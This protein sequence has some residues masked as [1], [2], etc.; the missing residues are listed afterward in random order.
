MKPFI[1]DEN[2]E[3]TYFHLFSHFNNIFSQKTS[4]RGC[5]LCEH[6]VISKEIMLSHKSVFHE[7]AVLYLFGLP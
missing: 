3:T 1:Q 4:V 2:Q 6:D 7:I 5:M